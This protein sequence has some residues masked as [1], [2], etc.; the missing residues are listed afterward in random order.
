MR[1]IPL[2][3]VLLALL[4]AQPATAATKSLTASSGDVEAMLSWKT[5]GIFVQDVRL[6]IVRA[7]LA[8]FD[9]PLMDDSSEPTIDL[10]QKLRVRDLDGD[11]EPEVVADLYTNGAHC[12]LYSLI[13]RYVASTP[14]AY[15]A[16]LHLWGNVGYRL[17]DLDGD[18]LPELESADDR[19][20]YAFTSFAGSGFPI[21]I[22]RYSGSGFEAGLVDVT[23]EF[24]ALVRKDAVVWWKAYVR[25]RG[26]RYGDVRGVLAAWLADK[27]LLGEKADGLHKLALIRKAGYLDGDGGWP[28]GKQYV[29]ELKTFLEQL[30][31]D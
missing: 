2:L 16:V 22:W 8:V 6:Q 24:P 15:H 7:G 5:G 31:Y 11:G 19:F 1:V 10:P 12:C 3:A 30:G 27:Y 29:A 18:G 26:K 14:A 4:A 20:A 21:Q 17:Q 23:T 25:G 28:S 13:Y 9:Q